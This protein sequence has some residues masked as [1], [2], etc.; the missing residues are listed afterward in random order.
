[1]NRKLDGLVF[2]KLTVLRPAKFL[3]KPRRFRWLCL[4]ECGNY[5]YAYTNNLYSG[6]KKSCGCGSH[7]FSA[8]GGSKSPEF[9]SWSAMMA[10]C[11][12]KKHPHYNQYGASGI[13]VSDHWKDFNNFV[14]DMGKPE[15]TNPTIERIDNALGYSKD[16]CRWASRTQQARNRGR[17]SNNSSGRTGVYRLPSGKYRA[18]IT[19]NKSLKSLGCFETYKQACGA[20]EVAEQSYFGFIK[21]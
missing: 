16:N 11:Y 5:C 6:G 15:I 1:M 12:N 7:K 13:L 14:D 3:G 9:A 21:E 8:K 2:H 10:R 18:T 20:R 17:F 4:C 19:V